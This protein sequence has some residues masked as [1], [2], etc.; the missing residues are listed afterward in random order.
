MPYQISY[1]GE[2]IDVIAAD[3]KEQ[4]LDQMAS[5]LNLTELG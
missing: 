3:S 1:N 4:A 2:S 5:K